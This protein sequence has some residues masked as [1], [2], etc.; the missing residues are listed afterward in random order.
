MML[1]S[2]L[3]HPRYCSFS[4]SAK[5]GLGAGWQSDPL[6]APYVRT[7]DGR[8]GEACIR[9]HLDGKGVLAAYNIGRPRDPNIEKTNQLL[10]TRRLD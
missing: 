3:P 1:S 5:W 4:R 8:Q 6:H 7:G 9:L 10:Q 2:L